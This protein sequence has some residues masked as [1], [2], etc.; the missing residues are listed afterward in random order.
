MLSLLLVVG[1]DNAA[2]GSDTTD[3]CSHEE[4]GAS[5]APNTFYD[6]RKLPQEP[7]VPNKDFVYAPLGIDRTQLFAVRDSGQLDQLRDHLGRPELFTSEEVDFAN[8]LIV[9]GVSRPVGQSS[10][11]RVTRVFELSDVIEVQVVLYPRSGRASVNPYHFV[12]IPRADKPI[13]VYLNGVVRHAEDAEAPTAGN[14]ERILRL[15]RHYQL[16]VPNEPAEAMPLIVLLHGSTID[17]RRYV[18]KYRDLAEQFGYALLAPSSTLGYYWHSDYDFGPV[19]GMIEEV[20]A[21]HN[22]DTHRIY[23]GG[24]SA[25]GHSVYSFALENRKVFS[26]FFSLSGRLNPAVPNYVVAKADGMPVFLMTGDADPLVPWRMVEASKERLEAA[27]ADVTY[28]LIPGGDHA[29]PKDPDNL[30]HVF[31]WLNEHE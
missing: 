16:F 20:V 18:K 13:R 10:Y 28:R 1:C 15:N 7:P 14:H 2:P 3:A 9:G 5:V 12:R 24:S 22:I 19:L 26:A 30:V 27:G 29:S 6:A 23:A 31:E 4:T 25:G 21:T 17:G 8:E 11:F